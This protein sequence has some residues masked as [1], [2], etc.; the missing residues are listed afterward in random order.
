MSR[1]GELLQRLRDVNLEIEIR[2]SLR[3]TIANWEREQLNTVRNLLD[4]RNRTEA[5]LTRE[6]GFVPKSEEPNPER[7]KR[8][9]EAAVERVLF[10]V[11]DLGEEGREALFAELRK[12]YPTHNPNLYPVPAAVATV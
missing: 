4:S 2:Q 1:T 8:L 3:G 7:D 12:R 11:R 9:R 10:Q 5:D 6:C